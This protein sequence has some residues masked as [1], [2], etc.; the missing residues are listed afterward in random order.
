MGETPALLLGPIAVD[1]KFRSHGLG[2]ALVRRACDVAEA[3]GYP[4]ILL[5]GDSAFFE[6]LGF[7]VARGVTLPGPV[8]KGRVLVRSLTGEPLK[9]PARAPRRV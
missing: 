7:E 8:D 6:P 9:G 5:V 3:A 4:H 1:P 2:A